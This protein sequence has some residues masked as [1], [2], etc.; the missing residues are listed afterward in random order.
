[1][2]K[3][4]K[5]NVFNYNDKVYYWTNKSKTKEIDF[6]YENTAFEV[7]YQNEINSEDYKGLKEFKNSYLLTKKTFNKKTYPLSGFLLLLE[8]YWL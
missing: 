1:M 8:K 3:N 2:T 7:K 6:I 4:T 5:S